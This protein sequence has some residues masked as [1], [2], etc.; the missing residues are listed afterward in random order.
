MFLRFRAFSFSASRSSVSA[1]GLAEADTEAK[2]E[3]VAAEAEVE[4]EAAKVDGLSA[5]HMSHLLRDAGLM[6]VQAQHA[7]TAVVIGGVACV[8]DVVAGDEC[9]LTGCVCGGVESAAETEAVADD[10]AE[11]NQPIR[12]VRFGS[13]AVCCG[14][15]C[16]R[17]VSSGAVCGCAVVAGVDSCV[18]AVVA[19]VGAVAEA[20]A[21]VAAGTN[22]RFSLKNESHTDT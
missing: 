6:K 4:A 9:V 18:A 14:S 3:A 10:S 16:S 17:S 22:W 1:G 2:A 19:V 11:A 8:I 7:A 21:E 5:L 15:V 20:A 13:V 12:P